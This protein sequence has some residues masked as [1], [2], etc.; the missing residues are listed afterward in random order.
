MKLYEIEDCDECPIRDEGICPGGW[1]SGAGGNPIEPP[2]TNWDGDEEVEDYINGYYAHIIA[3]EEYEDRLWKEQQEKKRKNEIARQ[4]RQYIK[5][6]CFSER[7]EVKRLQKLLNTYEK[8]ANFADSW[9]MAFNT[10]N[11]M[12]GYKERKQVNPEL[13]NKIESLKHELE[14]AKQK[15]KEKQKECRNTE[16]Y[17]SIG[18]ET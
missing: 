8:T 6:Y 16:Y 9:V 14:N 1:T 17:K 18:K 3:R 7:Y 5:M 11:E 2:C 10:T 4:K 15:L 13:I 12:F